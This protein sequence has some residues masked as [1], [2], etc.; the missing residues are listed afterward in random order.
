MR[1]CYAHL[2]FALAPSVALAQLPLQSARDPELV[3]NSPASIAATISNYTQD[4]E[5]LP[6]PP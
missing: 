3:I 5:N 2:A 6:I 4:V 1:L